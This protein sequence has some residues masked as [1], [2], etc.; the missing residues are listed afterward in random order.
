MTRPAHHARLSPPSLPL[1]KVEWLTSSG[2][3][4]WLKRDWDDPEG[5]D[6]LRSIKR[7][8]ALFMFHDA[9]QKQY[10]APGKLI[11]S[12]TSGNLGIELAFLARQ[13]G[14]PFYCVAPGAILPEGLEIL[15]AVGANVIRTTEREVCPREFTVFYTRGYAHEFHHRLVNLDQ[16]YSWLNP[17]SHCRTTAREIFEESSIRVDA[18]AACLGSCGTVGGIL[19]Y[20]ESKKLDVQ[21]FGAQPDRSQ[22]I[23]GTHVIRGDCRWSPE[24]YSP[25][26]LPDRNVLTVDNVDSFAFSVKL[27]SE[28]VAAGPSTGMA[29]A[30]ADRQARAG[31]RG[32]I[33]VISAD[34]NL[35]YPG[36]IRSELIKHREEILCRYPELDLGR[37]IERAIE[38]ADRDIGSHRTE[39]RIQQAYSVS[40]A[41]A[42]FDAEEIEEIVAGA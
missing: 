3:T 25:V 37:P 42:I 22:G 13:H 34:S 36:L 33:V 4:F 2:A 15:R 5:P 11:I 41:G 14:F 18:V 19:S 7:K 27:W 30:L 1:Q 17:L 31:L 32:N 29:L 38:E 24:N 21:V 9:M 39:R 10:L 23:P 8:P 20:I 16:F 6:P 28:G 12:A 26:V 35:K 40:S